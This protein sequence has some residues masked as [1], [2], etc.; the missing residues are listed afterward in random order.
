M[1]P[2]RK[3][4]LT[5]ISII[6]SLIIAIAFFTIF[7]LIYSSNFGVSLFN[8]KNAMGISRPFGWY[9][10]K[11]NFKGE[12]KWGDETFMVFTDKYGFRVGNSTQMQ[13]EFYKDADL[14]F[15]GDSFTFGGST[16]WRDSYVGMIEASINLKII[17]AGVYSYSPT[18]Y[19]HQ[20]KSVINQQLLK[21]GHTVVVAIDISDIQDES[22]YRT[23]G[24][25]HPIS[26]TQIKN[27]KESH[28]SF[29]KRSIAELK[30]F[31]N[32][33]LTLTN[34]IVEKIK[35]QQNSFPAPHSQSETYDMPRSAFTW[36]DWGNLNQQTVKINGIE[37]DGYLPLGVEG[38]LER[39]RSKFHEIANLAKKN[40]AKVYILAYP[41]PAQI[42]Y[43]DHFSWSN[44]LVEICQKENCNGLIDTTSVFRNLASRNSDWQKKF[45]IPGDIH[46]NQEGNKILADSVLKKINKSAP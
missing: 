31:K 2:I 14:I 17:N 37:G 40:D 22:A 29:M 9:E 33:H 16:S 21:P 43:S 11:K 34:L 19:L 32:N 38:G 6:T 30:S 45:Y 41:W 23:D 13:R 8:R 15:L 26:I 24:I 25:E 36:E 1:T 28:S 4:Y 35:H 5:S 12:S 39:T 27:E 7:D 20:Y 42:H 10:L 44:F 18:A 3:I 46:F